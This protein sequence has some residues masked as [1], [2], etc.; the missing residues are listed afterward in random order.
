MVRVVILAL[1]LIGL[2]GCADRGR[3]CTDLNVPCTAYL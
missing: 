3:N 1:I 2:S